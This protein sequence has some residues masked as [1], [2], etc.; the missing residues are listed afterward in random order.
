MESVPVRCS[1][2]HC[3]HLLGEVG[4]SEVLSKP[5]PVWRIQPGW[6]WRNGILERIDETARQERSLAYEVTGREFIPA[7]GRFT[8][9]GLNLTRE[10]E[11]PIAVRCPQCHRPRWVDA[12]LTPR[13]N[14][15]VALV[16]P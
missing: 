15:D 14:R 9:A 10:A 6:T 2:T 12:D 4:I 3:G 7:G 1:T 8:P 11:L 16:R 5:R 13:S